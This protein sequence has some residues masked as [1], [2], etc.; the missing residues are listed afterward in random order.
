MRV[1]Q[2]CPYFFPHIGG[3]ESHVLDLSRELVARGHTVTVVTSDPGDRPR[4]EEV[5]G[6]RVVRVRPRL[7][8]LTSPVTPALRRV[9]RDREADVVHAHSP[10]PLSAYY[11]ARACRDTG[12]P[13]IVTYHCDLELPRVWGTLVTTL[14][15]R[16]LEAS[17]LRTAKRVVA[18]SQTYAATSRTVWRHGVRVIPMAVDARRFNPAVDGASA[19]RTLDPGDRTVVLFVGRL[20]RH[21]GVEYLLQAARAIPE[22]LFVIVGDGP[23]AEEYRALAV[24]LQ[25]PNVRF[26]GRVSES[27]LP[28][29]YAACDL[30]VLPSVSRL[31][32]FGTVALEAMASSKPVVLSDIPGVREVITHGR[33]GLLAEPLNASDLASKVRE[34][35]GDEKLRW[36]MGDLGRRKVEE[37]YNMQRVAGL[38]EEVYEGALA[39]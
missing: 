19:R 4:E 18:T 20:V 15:R 21:K 35:L 37:V 9:L 11:A 7:T 16:T 5:F 39:P 12:R 10:P 25:V 32:A 13:L 17:T 23:M 14:Y 27:D 3:V 24:K 2:V 29:Y 6:F 30:F 8:W 31:E 26:V 34:L 36:R 38:V 22:G 28:G 33:E 1:V